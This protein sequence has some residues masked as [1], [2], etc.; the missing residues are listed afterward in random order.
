MDGQNII[1]LITHSSRPEIEEG[2]LEQQ[3]ILR[4]FI[5]FENAKVEY[6]L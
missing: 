5:L 4:T 6:P 3:R 1:Q 2:Y